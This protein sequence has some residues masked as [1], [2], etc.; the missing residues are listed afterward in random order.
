M[1]LN[2][3]MVDTEKSDG[4]YSL[5]IAEDEFTGLFL[6]PSVFSVKLSRSE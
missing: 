3:D 4:I 6:H 1:F 2:D 5:T